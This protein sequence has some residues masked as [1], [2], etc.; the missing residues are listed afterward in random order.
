MALLWILLG[1]TVIVLIARYNEDD[2]LFWKLFVSFIGAYLAAYLVLSTLNNNRQS[3]QNT[4]AYPTQGLSYAVCTMPSLCILSEAI[5][6]TP[7]GSGNNQN[8]VGQDIYAMCTKEVALSSKV[9]AAARDQ[10]FTYFDTS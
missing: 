1:I 9:S 8:L 3:D 2:S 6:T 4:E 10:P 5:S 7:V